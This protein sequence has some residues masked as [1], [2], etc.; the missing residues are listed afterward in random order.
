MN[1]PLWTPLVKV[2]LYIVLLGGLIISELPVLGQTFGEYLGDESSFY[3]ETKQLNQFIRRFNAEEKPDGSRIYPGNPGYR[4]A[5]FRRKFI[6]ILFDMENSSLNRGLKQ[7]FISDVTRA[8]APKYVSFHGGDWFAEVKVQVLFKN[9]PREATLFMQLQEE[10]VGSKWVFTQV[11]FEPFAEYFPKL[12]S[13]NGI[14]PFLHP[15]S[16]EL[17]FMNLKK[18]FRDV[19]QIQV[20]AAREY[21]PDH[22]SLFLYEIKKGNI[23]FESVKQVKFHFFQVEDWYFELTEFNRRGKNRGWLISQ[24]VQVPEPQKDLLRKYIYHE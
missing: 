15:M 24:L 14:P 12:D 20:Y 2:G 7:Q 6:E 22:L 21:F 13:T 11:F 1:E 18:I 3:A 9:R 16:H 23:R 4:N 19:N 8:S 17:D 10:P 5:A